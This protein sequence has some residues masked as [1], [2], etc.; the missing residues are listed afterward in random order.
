MGHIDVSSLYKISLM[1]EVHEAMGGGTFYIREIKNLAFSQTHWR[2]R[3][4]ET[5]QNN[6]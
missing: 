3:I 6:Y 2:L 5:L 1:W 4:F